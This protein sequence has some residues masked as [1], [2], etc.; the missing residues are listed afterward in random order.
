MGRLAA[1]ISTRMLLSERHLVI[2]ETARAF[3]DSEIRSVAA[4]LDER[5][6]SLTTSTRR[7][8]RRAS[9]GEH[10]EEDA[11]SEPTHWHTL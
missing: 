5:E 7:W 10:S 6:G 4:A 8:R 1:L 11:A 9:S 2:Q 3:A